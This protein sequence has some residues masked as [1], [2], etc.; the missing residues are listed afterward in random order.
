[1]KKW[2]KVL[3]LFAGIAFVATACFISWSYGFRQ[4]I[5]AGGLT[6]NMAEFTLLN[7]HMTDQLANA[8]CEG[9]KQ[10]LN[11]YLKHL[12]KYRDVKGSFISDTV[13][14]GDKMLTHVR[15]AWIEEHMENHAEA[16]RHMAIAKE[17]CTQRKWE[18]CSEEK[19]VSFAKRWEEK[20]PIGC[21][22]SKK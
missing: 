14:Y 16:Q 13:Y 22:S 1:M 18:D 8:N 4:G 10:A 5:R 19:V 9:A 21:L 17:A 2:K 12:D 6:S 3:L 7:Q 15:L 20:N 11:D